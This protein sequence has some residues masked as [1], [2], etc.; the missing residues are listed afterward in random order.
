MLS[1]LYN[2]ALM[3]KVINEEFGGNRW[4]LVET[5]GNQ[6][7]SLVVDR[8]YKFDSVMTN[9]LLVMGKVEVFCHKRM[10]YYDLKYFDLL[11]DES[12]SENI[13]SSG[14]LHF[15]KMYSFYYMMLDVL[16]E[17]DINSVSD[18]LAKLGGYKPAIEELKNFVDSV[19]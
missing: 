2:P 11:T 12:Y 15:G 13:H 14:L 4:K 10:D 16:V 9:D 17:K 5:L 8:I 19:R 6:N 1:I 7:L 18:A 3:K